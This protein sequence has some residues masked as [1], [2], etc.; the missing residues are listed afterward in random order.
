MGW[1]GG[2]KSK[3]DVARAYASTQAEHIEVDG[4]E[5]TVATIA[6]CFRGN[7]LWMVS[8]V[9]FSDGRPSERLIEVVLISSDKD[10]I[11]VKPMDEM[12]G[13][14]ATSCPAKYLKM[15]PPDRWSSKFTEAQRETALEW[16]KRVEEA[17]GPI[18]GTFKL[19]P[20]IVVK[21]KDG[22]MVP[23]VRIIS[24]TPFVGSFKG[25][26]YQVKRNQ[27]DW[28]YMEAHR[29]YD[30]VNERMPSHVAGQWF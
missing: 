28:G 9:A 6:H 12:A 19:K 30:P 8:E 2:Y 18:A 15:V 24:T 29:S 21:L 23:W 10:G 26:S 11:F 22:L 25:C 13:P 3:A 17:R 20:G 1:F 7:S 27:V 4:C 14:A 5:A 16:R